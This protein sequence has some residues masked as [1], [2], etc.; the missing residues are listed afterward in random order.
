MKKERAGGGAEKEKRRAALAV[1]KKTECDLEAG[2]IFFSSLPLSTFSLAGQASLGLSL[3]L[4]PNGYP[5]EF[6]GE[7]SHS[8]EHSAPVS[9]VASE[10]DQKLSTKKRARAKGR[11]RQIDKVGKGTAKR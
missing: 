4:F 6:A 9:G 10:S 5:A 11:E 2:E 3:S 1:E 8:G 7:C